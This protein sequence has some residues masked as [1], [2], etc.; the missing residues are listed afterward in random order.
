VTTFSLLRPDR[1][2]WPGS[3]RRVYDLAPVGELIHCQDV[4][5]G[6]E[7]VA[8]IVGDLRPGKARTHKSSRSHS[9]CFIQADIDS[10]VNPWEVR[11]GSYAIPLS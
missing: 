3:H 7:A 1:A 8:P 4:R 9:C 11:L 5:D 10:T 2:W 6:Q